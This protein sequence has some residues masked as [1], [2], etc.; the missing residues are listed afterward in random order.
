MQNK[1]LRNRDLMTGDIL[2]FENT[3]DHHQRQIFYMHSIFPFFRCSSNI[4]KNYKYVIIEPVFHFDATAA[5]I[6]QASYSS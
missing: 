6:L 2:I 4:R 1:S 5:A 3:K